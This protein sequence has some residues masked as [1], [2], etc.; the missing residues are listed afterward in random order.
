MQVAVRKRVFCKHL[1]SANGTDP[2]PFFVVFLCS[3]P[4]SF[5]SSHCY[6]CKFCSFLSLQSNRLS[7]LSFCA[8]FLCPS[9]LRI[10]TYVSSFYS[11]L[12]LYIIKS[13]YSLR[14]RVT[15]LSG[16]RL[17]TL[18]SVLTLSFYVCT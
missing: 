7:L 3:V 10:S 18:F 2:A 4:L 11:F 1:D 9:I 17:H 12:S 13:F 8:Q 14:R 5:H 15:D 6:V 16:L